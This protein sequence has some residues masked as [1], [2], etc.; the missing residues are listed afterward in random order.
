MRSTGFAVFGSHPVF[1]PLASAS[2]ELAILYNDRIQ[3]GSYSA[4]KPNGT[5]FGLSICVPPW[6]RAIPRAEMLWRKMT[7]KNANCCSTI[8]SAQRKER[9]CLELLLVIWLQLR[10]RLPIIVD[11][12][13]NA[14]PNEHHVPEFPNQIFETKT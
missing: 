10:R 3:P 9:A 1:L 8:V 14:P 7:G 11:H 5:R 4:S 13:I 6:P 12:D 2:R